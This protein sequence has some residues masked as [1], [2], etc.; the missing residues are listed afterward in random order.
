MRRLPFLFLGL[1][2]F[3]GAVAAAPPDKPLELKINLPGD[4]PP[5]PMPEFRLPVKEADPRARGL[6]RAKPQATGPI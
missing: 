1:S 2:L 3:A 5:A 4:G 6:G